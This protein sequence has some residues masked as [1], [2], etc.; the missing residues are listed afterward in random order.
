[1]RF[2]IFYQQLISHFGIVIVAFVG[3]SLVVS[4][5]VEGL[6]FQYKE[7]ELISYGKSILED[8]DSTLFEKQLS[9]SE[10]QHILSERGIDFSLFN[11][12][13]QF[14]YPLENRAWRIV[15]S[16]DEWK[17]ILQGKTIVEHV[18]YKRFGKG[19]SIVIL[20][21]KVNQHFYGGVLL[22]S[23]IEGINELVSRFNKYLLITVLIATIVT[24]LM[25]WI[26]SKI[27]V[28][29]INELKQAASIVASG[30]YDVE[31][32]ATGFDEIGELA[33]NFKRMVEKLRASKE[34]I[35]SLENR[36][37]QF[38]ADVSH[39]MRTPLTTI[40]G[41]VEG[42]KNDLIPESERQKGLELVSKE[43]KRLI[44]LVNENLDYEKIRSNQVVLNKEWIELN[45][46]FEII[47][48]QLHLQAKEKKNDLI[49]EVEGNPHIYADYDR[50]VQILLNITKNSIQFTD[51][52][53]IYLRGS[54]K[55]GFTLIEIEDT[56]IGIDAEEIE[57]IWR[58]FY[59]ADIS[60]KSNPFGEFGLGLSIVK[61][62]V[63]LHQGQITVNSEKGKGTKFSLFFPLAEQNRHPEV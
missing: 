18:D 13:G 24:F 3:I 54:E 51:Q 15:F 40:S 41:V 49:I 60:R 42:L 53:Q 45:E 56:G 22:Y 8:L 6:V 46:V 62:L 20:P 59:K 58:R 52:G 31:I 2:K 1:M 19:V 10:Y 11:S 5:Y 17:Q 55:E 9:L 57:K 63:E 50:L 30:S 28:K 21:Y 25:S 27:H 34:E 32:T 4:H 35:E 38:I 12:R 44:R 36:R 39:E 47:A 16:D 29:R 37:R 33:T 43:T 7:E 23:P 14:V 48:E 26:S 61:K